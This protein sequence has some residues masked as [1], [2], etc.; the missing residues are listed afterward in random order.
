MTYPA[1]LEHKLGFVQIR[2]LLKSYCL[3]ELGIREVDAMQ[4]LTVAGP[5]STLLTRNRE[6]LSIIVK[7]DAFPFTGY[8]DPAP[9]LPIIRPEGG[10]LEEEHLH[11]IAV[12]LRSAFDAVT[13]LSNAKNEFPTLSSL[14]GTLTLKI[15]V[16][17]ALQSKLNDDGKIRDNATPELHRIRRQLEG[18]RSRIRK[19]TDQVFR[20]AASQG[21]IPDG[22]SPTLRDGRLVIP[23]LAE[24]K[25]RIKGVVVD[26]SSTGQTIYIE[27]TEVLEASNELRDLELAERREVIRVLREL[28]T[29]LRENLEDFLSAYQLLAW[30]DLER[31]KAKVAID[32]NSHLPDIADE[33]ALDWINAR[34]PG[35]VLNL[36]GKRSVVPLNVHLSA[37]DRFLLVSGPNAGGKSVCLKTVGL[38]QYM[39][40]CGMLVPVEESSKMGLFQN[41]F[42]D[43]GDQQSIENDLS[44]YSSHLRNMQ[45]FLA[46]AGSE[47][48]VLMDELGSGTDPNFGGGI[49]Q[50][51]LAELLRAGAWGV[52]TTHYYNLKVFASQTPGIINGAMMFDAQNLQPLFVLEIGRP[53]SSFALEIARKTGLSSQVLQS[54]EEIIGRDLAGL[55]TLMKS[56]ADEKLKNIKMTAE[57]RRKENELHSLISEYETLSAQLESRKKE[58]IEKAKLEATGLLRETNKEI[59]KT[60]RHI[61][62]NRA[63]RSETRKVRQNLKDLEA[64]VKRSEDTAKRDELVEPLKEGDKVRMR[65][66]EVTGTLQE[67]KGKNAVVQFGNLR[68][69]V[70]I[71]QLVRSNQAEPVEAKL[72]S[73]T[74]IDIQRR[75]SEFSGLLD[76]R[77]R[78]VEE[79]L[80]LITQFIDDA[81]LVGQAEVRILHGKGE[82]VLRKVIRD[83]L[84]KV[85]HVAAMNDEHADRGGA[86]ITVVILK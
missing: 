18:E 86:G 77:G 19:L 43:I 66:Q 44:T 10:F 6:M 17:K 47:S 82:G 1:D 69:H 33:P 29:L 28:T 51:V 46:N 52:A 20:H 34:H 8:F 27:P 80:P 61:K 25:R 42:I 37:K 12:S 41:L 32:L 4:F 63:E 64:K 15:A 2:A 54:A 26:E 13:F 70:R 9:L 73:S 40:Q 81:V 24:H 78:R 45:F 7:G 55:E 35:L 67:L 23:V 72:R 62:E 11:K 56:V 60:I 39:L 79:V 74:G 84:R 65:G 3:S 50:A 36:R 16:L 58:I 31:A 22:I 53:G 14:A 48:L 71:E 85:P 59:E 30:L 38:I 83:Y 76:I 49:A 21:W 75:Q 5:I 57:L 68:S